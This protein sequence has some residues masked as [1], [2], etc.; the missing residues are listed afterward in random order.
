MESLNSSAS[1][2]EKS[3]IASRS[4]AP[5][6]GLGSKRSML[7]ATIPKLHVLIVDD[8]HTCRKMLSRLLSPENVITE[9]A[10]DGVEAVDMVKTSEQKGFRYDLILMD[11]SMP[12][13][14]GLEATKIIREMGFKGKIFGVTGNALA[15]DVNDFINHGADAVHIKP[16]SKEQLSSMLEGIFN[17]NSNA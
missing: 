10:K 13:M 15:E 3:D 5:A 12:K 17:T 7:Q 14:T 11:A 9:E 8:V 1:N 6:K 2:A 4:K 16:V